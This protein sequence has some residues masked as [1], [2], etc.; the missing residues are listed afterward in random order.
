MM[1]G[2]DAIVVL[3]ILLLVAV[4]GAFI[5]VAVTVFSQAASRRCPVCKVEF[6]GSTDMKEHM[7]DHIAVLDFL[8]PQGKGVAIEGEVHKAA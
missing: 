7:K 2:Y 8:L 1:V 5:A 6:L 3:P 4:F